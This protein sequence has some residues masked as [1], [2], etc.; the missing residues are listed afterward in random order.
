MKNYELMTITKLSLGEEGA[1]ALSNEVKDL[2]NKFKGTVLNDD[3]WGK[4]KYAYTLNG[5][6]EGFYDVIKLEMPAEEMPKFK[7]KLNMQDKVVRYLVI[8]DAK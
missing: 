7:A 8:A 4:R 2:V 5:E 1:R 6:T 3:F